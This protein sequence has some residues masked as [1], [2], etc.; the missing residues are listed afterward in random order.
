MKGR[1][2]K[3]GRGNSDINKGKRRIREVNEIE[4]KVGK[5]GET[6]RNKGEKR[7]CREGI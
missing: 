6:E 4:E 7:G 1:E 5:D 3:T 2:G